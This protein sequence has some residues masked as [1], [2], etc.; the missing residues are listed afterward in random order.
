[1]EIVGFMMWQTTNFGFVDI[2]GSSIDS[3]S[4]IN[5]GMNVLPLAI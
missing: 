3:T 5:L 4:S 2:G 1:M